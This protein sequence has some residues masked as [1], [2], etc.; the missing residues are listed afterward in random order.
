MAFSAAQGYASS[1]SFSPA[2]ASSSQPQ[3]LSG[4]AA[5]VAATSGSG[6]GGAW[7]HVVWSDAR[8]N[9]LL[10]S[11]VPWLK[12]TLRAMRPHKPVDKIDT[13]RYLLLFLFGG[14]YLDADQVSTSGLDKGRA[15][16]KFNR[17]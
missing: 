9:S 14:V 13:M 11:A 2:A 6:S 16:R 7:A 5:G 4:P 8:L 1:S 15:G 10:A 3:A 17:A 12:P